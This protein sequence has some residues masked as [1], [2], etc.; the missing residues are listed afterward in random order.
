[1]N[2]ERF[3]VYEHIR[4]DTGAVFYV[5]KGSG[6]R[7]KHGVNRGVYWDRVVNKAGGYSINY[8]V[9][10]VDE[11]LSLL[12][13]MELIDQ[14]RKTGVQLV[15]VSAGGEG[16]TGWI[17]TEETKRKIGLANKTTPKAS[18]ES[19]GMYGKK[20]T[21]ESLAKMSVSQNAREWGENHPFYGKHHSD[22]SKA[23]IS[24]NR[25]GKALGEANHFYG[26]THTEETRAKISKAN[27]GRIVS[28][29]TKA[30]KSASALAGAP[31]NKL[32]KPVICLTNGIT[33]YG[34]NEASKQLK[35][36]RQCI[37]MV[38]N[39]KLKQTGGYQFQWSIK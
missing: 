25:K 24:A 39:G 38:C 36:H 34:L 26:K 4:N 8:P 21:A 14:Y 17:P 31:T 2:Q 6:H 12:A 9:K 5:G 7:A 30:K 16:T 33:Y 22:E 23:K 29:E 37:R 3:Y 35:L 32:S 28:N 19:H 11:E 18:G 15:N 20:H 13:E 27:T 1:M 10:N